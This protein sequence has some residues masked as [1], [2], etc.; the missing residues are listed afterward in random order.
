[1]RVLRVCNSSCEKRARTSPDTPL[2]FIRPCYLPLSACGQTNRVYLAKT[3]QIRVHY[4]DLPRAHFSVPLSARY[5]LMKHKEG[6]IR[7]CSRPDEEEQPSGEAA[8]ENQL[9]VSTEN[10]QNISCNHH[11]EHDLGIEARRRSIPPFLSKDSRHN[12]GT[13]TLY[14]RISK[15]FASY[16]S[17]RPLCSEHI[18]SAPSHVA[19][20]RIRLI[21]SD[22]PLLDFIVR[23]APSRSLFGS[24]TSDSA[25]QLILGLSI[26]FV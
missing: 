19:H 3:L 13:Y 23:L 25:V 21:I 17:T 20:I 12:H 7:D 9:S 18:S 26:L 15:G 16:R 10:G 14:T 2:S 22:L 5:E 8:R 6:K 24:C 1:M 11:V 4:R